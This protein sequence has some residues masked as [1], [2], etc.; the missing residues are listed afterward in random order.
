MSN[1]AALHVIIHGRV[2]GVCY[3]MFVAKKA[4][5]L[6]L[7]GYVRNL[8]TGEDVE[9]Q[10]EG[11]KEQLENLIEQLKIGPPAAIVEK[12]TPIW[13]KFTKKDTHFRIEN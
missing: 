13:S 5:E 10:A 12:V 3:R 11:E 4:A 2:Q 6:A 8:P 9:V 7:T 1:L